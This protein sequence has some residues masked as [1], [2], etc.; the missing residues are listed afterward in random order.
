MKN[1]TKFAVIGLV[2]MA[3]LVLAAEKSTYHYSN[4]I[5]KD[6]VERIKAKNSTWTPMEVEK[7]PLIKRSDKFF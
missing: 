6:I 7:N 3:S 4:Y 5:N 1:F 2:S